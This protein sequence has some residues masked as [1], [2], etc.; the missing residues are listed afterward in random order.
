MISFDFGA[1]KEI[2]N[3][4]T[5]NRLVQTQQFKKHLLPCMCNSKQTSVIY[6]SLQI[7]VIEQKKEEQRA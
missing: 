3:F 5:V 4:E 6:S 7:Q 2:R 1:T